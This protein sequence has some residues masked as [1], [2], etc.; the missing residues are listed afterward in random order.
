MNTAELIEAMKVMDT[1]N[2]E[3]IEAMK[4]MNTMNTERNAELIAAAQK[5]INGGTN[6]RLAKHTVLYDSRGRMCE[7]VVQVVEFE[8][9]EGVTKYLGTMF[10]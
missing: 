7:E 2:T 6:F 10:L 9:R 3:L 5:L 4:F 8:D 1:M